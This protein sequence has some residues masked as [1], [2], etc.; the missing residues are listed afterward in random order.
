MA[1]YLII[2]GAGASFGSDS[3]NVP[4]LGSGLFSALQKF[5]P[6]G[7]GKIDGDLA[8]SFQSDFEATMPKVNSHA[9][10][11]LQRVMADYF[12]RFQPTHNNLYYKL[13]NLIAQK[14]WDGAFVT[15]NY[16]RLLEISLLAAKI[17][18][19]DKNTTT[20]KFIELCLP[21][22]ACN[23]F[24]ESVKGLAS[25]VSFAGLNVQ[26]NGPIIGIRD[27]NTFQQRI[28]ND[29]FPPVMS[30]FEPSKRTTS[31]ANFI[32]SQR[33]RF[34]ELVEGAEKIAIIGLRV[35]EHDKHIWEPLSKTNAKIIYCAGNS[36]GDEFKKWSNKNREIKTDLLVLNSYF[37]EGFEELMKSIDL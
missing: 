16:E 12:F 4:P 35:R 19:F 5:N 37:N 7:W 28:Q 14:T 23:L 11:P 1:K 13:A 6:N 25:A 8:N 26:T 9:L 22:G 17:N 33:K 31:G 15:L 34:A 3:N 2:F 27:A 21:H 32:E 36:A 29:A 30:Y 18:P 24:C 10:P 20:E